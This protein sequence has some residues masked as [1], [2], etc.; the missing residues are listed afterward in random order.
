MNSSFDLSNFILSNF[1]NLI[2]VCLDGSNYVTWKFLLETMLKGCGLMKYVDGSF[3]CPSQYLITEEDGVTCEMTR[4]YITWKQNDYA[5]MALLAATLSSDVV[6]FVVGSN[7]SREFW[8]LLKERFASTSWFNKEQLKTNFYKLQKGS[9]SIDKYLDRVKM[10]CDQL[11]NVGI[12]MTDEDIVVSVLLGLPSDYTT[13][14]TIIRAKHN[15]ISMQELRSLLLIAEV[16]LEEVDKSISLPSNTEIVAQ[17]DNFRG[18]TTTPTHV[19]DA[20]YDVTTLMPPSTV[21]YSRYMNGPYVIASVPT[22][23]SPYAANTVVQ[24][25]NSIM[26]LLPTHDPIFNQWYVQPQGNSG[27]AYNIGESQY[28]EAFNQNEGLMQQHGFG[29]SQ[30]NEGFSHQG[31]SSSIMCRLCKR[32]GH[33]ASRCYHRYSQPQ[34]TLSSSSFNVKCQICHCFGHIAPSCSQRSAPR[35]I[36]TS[37]ASLRCQICLKTGHSAAECFHRHHYAFQPPTSTIPQSI[38]SS[39]SSH[40][41]PIVTG[42]LASLCY[43]LLHG[44]ASQLLPLFPPG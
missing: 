9:D 2:S 27:Y 3:P 29:F 12:H 31:Y 42:A 21:A 14:K 6:S 41:M 1:C 23:T 11:A 28:N 26:Q 8:C 35:Q 10:A 34:N 20:K 7:T 44:T 30:Q 19:T 4:E 17:G 33:S 15:L 38:A 36:V 13:M 32:I 18:T 40:P 39:F 22:M 43:P 5:V 16:E 25:K 24:N 37:G